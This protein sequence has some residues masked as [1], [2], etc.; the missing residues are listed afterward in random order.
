MEQLLPTEP[1]FVNSYHHQA[2][3]KTA[4][5]FTVSAYASDGVVEAMEDSARHIYAIQWHLEELVDRYERFCPLFR[6]LVEE[7]GK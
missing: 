5:D 1:H 3:K 6:Y 4:P 2:L 7:A